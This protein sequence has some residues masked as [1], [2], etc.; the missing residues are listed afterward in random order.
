MSVFRSDVVGR[1]RRRRR[2]SLDDVVTFPPDKIVFRTLATAR[3]FTLV[4]AYVRRR[5]RA[6]RSI[7]GSFR[8]S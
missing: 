8:G 6:A 4:Y 7:R 2:R 1:C 3:A 5:S